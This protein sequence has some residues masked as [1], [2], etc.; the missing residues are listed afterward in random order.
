MPLASQADGL[1]PALTPS[2]HLD[3]LSPW[4]WTPASTKRPCHSWQPTSRGSS[5]RSTGPA[6][7][8]PDSRMRQC[9][10]HLPKYYR[11]RT[12]SGSSR[13]S[14]RSWRDRSPRPRQAPARHPRLTSTTPDGAYTN[15]SVRPS[16]QSKE[17]AGAASD[18]TPRAVSRVRVLPRG[19][20]VGDGSGGVPSRAGPYRVLQSASPPAVRST[21]SQLRAPGLGVVF[22]PG[23]APPGAT[24]RHRLRSRRRTS[25][26]GGS[27]GRG[28]CGTGWRGTTG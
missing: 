22:S 24:A 16:H 23:P 15:D 26:C 8:T 10:K 7:H 19:T 13:R 14:S 28:G 2:A 12:L 5:G 11:T 6:P 20:E 21:R 3:R 4:P 25:G 17:A 1:P 9:I 27:R 18:R